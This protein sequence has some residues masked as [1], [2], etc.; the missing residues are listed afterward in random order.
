MYAYNLLHV[1]YLICYVV[2][3]VMERP[4]CGFSM[5]HI[6]SVIFFHNFLME[7]SHLVIKWYGLT[8]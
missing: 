2:V 8:K 3:A 5:S 6:V 4:C 7:R 1:S